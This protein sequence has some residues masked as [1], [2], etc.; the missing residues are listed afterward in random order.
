M[1]T[2]PPSSAC[3]AL[4]TAPANRHDSPLLP[5]TLER[6]GAGGFLLD[7]ARVHLDRGYDSGPTRTRLLERG[8][9]A[10]ISRKGRPA[11]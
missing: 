9:V 3:G 1:K 11:P 4:V 10:E 7:G 6:V 2:R 5:E 8:L